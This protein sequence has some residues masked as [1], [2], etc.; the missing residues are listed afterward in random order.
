MST[1]QKK[2]RI[3]R[4]PHCGEVG[5]FYVEGSDGVQRPAKSVGSNDAAACGVCRKRIGSA[6]KKTTRAQGAAWQRVAFDFERKPFYTPAEVSQIADISDQTVLQ[7]IH[8]GELYAAR[9]G[10]LFR[11]PLGA[12]LQ[13]L[14]A[15]PEIRWTRN[16]EAHVDAR[17]DGLVSTTKPANS[18]GSRAARCSDASSLVCFPVIP[19]QRPATTWSAALRSRRLFADAARRRRLPRQDSPVASRA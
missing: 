17:T 6:P 10:R 1:P 5:R 4:C 19:I 2:G 3:R 9:L 11:V 7:R 8:D 18:S 16:P 14:G 15:P 12:L 13:F